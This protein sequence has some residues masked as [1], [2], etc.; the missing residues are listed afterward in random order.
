MKPL[1]SAVPGAL[2]AMLRSGPISQ[3]KVDF[4]WS[5]VV[6]P[7]LQRVTAVRLEGGTLIVDAAS[8][9]WGREVARSTGMILKRLQA[10]LGADTV[11]E[12]AIRHHA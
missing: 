9:Q 12:I 11:R 3:G 2:A 6:G 5:A 1:A 10:L 4:A 7:A 8:Q